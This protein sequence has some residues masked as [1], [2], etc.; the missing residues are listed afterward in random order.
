METFL[1]EV[2]RRLRADH[3]ADLDKVTVV[4]NNRRS[5]LFLRRQ[6]AQLSLDGQQAFFLPRIM[7]IDE[8]VAQLGGC[9]I[10]PNEFLL[11]ELF[12]IHRTIGGEGR[13]FATFEEFISFGDMMLA[14]FA[15]IDLYCVDVRQLFANL[16]D[17][18]AIGEWDIET[19]RLTDFQRRY[20]SFYRS[21]YDYYQQLHERLR[22]RGLAYS[23]M[24][25]RQVAEDIDRLAAEHPMA[26]VYFVGFNALSAAEKRIVQHYVRAGQGCLLTDGDDYYYSNPTQ[27]AGLFLRRQQSDFPTIGGYADHFAASPKEITIVSCPEDVA[28]CK[29]AGELLDGLMR[30]H[31]GESLEQVALVLADESLLVPAL[32]ALPGSVPT[33]NV[34]M[35]YPFTGTAVHSLM[36]K[37]FSLQLRRRG[38]GFNHQDLRDLLT[39]KCLAPMLRSENSYQHLAQLFAR[40]NILY[41][42]PALVRQ[43][44][45]EMHYNITP[46]EAILCAEPPTPDAFLAVVSDLAQR[47]FGSGALASNPREEEALGCLMEIVRHF[48]QL[49][50]QYHYVTKLTELQ[51]IYLR[52]AQRRTVA[53]YGEPLA[54][55]QV[56]GVLETRNLDFRRVILL[57]ANEGTLPS[58]RSHNSL[59]PFNLKNAFGIPTYREKEAVYAYNFY[60]LLQRA[61][62]VHILYNTET[63]GSM[64]K[65]EPSRFVLQVRDELAKCYP[66]TIAVREQVLNV[67][68]KLSTEVAETTTVA[69]DEATM[70]WLRQKAQN[71]FSPTSLNTYRQC[72]LKFYYEYV[73]GARKQDELDDEIG[74]DQLGTIIHKVLEQGYAAAPDG[75]VSEAVLQ[76]ALDRLD[77]LLDEACA[78]LFLHG[79]Q[80]EGKN[81]LMRAVAR[82]QL[83]AFLQAELQRLGQGQHELCVLGLEKPLEAELDIAEGGTPQT[84]H[85]TG[86][87]DRIDSL[88]GIVRIV[89][90]KTGTV[91]DS[92]L[93]AK[94]PNGAD[95][96]DMYKTGPKWF[97]VMLYAW[98]WRRMNPHDPRPL[99][100]GIFALKHLRSDLKVASWDGQEIITAEH[101]DQFGQYLTDLLAEILNPDLPL[102]ATPS[103]SSGYCS[104]CPFQDTCGH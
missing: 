23:G 43:L 65:G 37:L 26:P 92:E 72:P 42:D 2:A 48:Q 68:L 1:A 44:C 36:L 83:T 69:K 56:L 39:D 99:T 32:N 90:Y 16:H 50:E 49:Q 54:G 81:Y 41:A 19:G 7:G 27:E 47:L 52:L 94:T 57:S 71:G 45:Q 14:D 28:Q 60:R 29:Y 87:A 40:Q 100:S 103:S 104:Y 34:T 89:D 96:I 97:Q 91:K 67:P 66:D 9:E 17:L 86:M 64:G 6:F 4:F 63:D 74:S 62:S 101:L 78:S 95:T 53:F 82:K 21:L 13:K 22:Q 35:G 77:T 73:L 11:F 30:D 58:A 38:T 15:E 3:P 76:S 84:V 46:I 70:A 33:A 20:L 88:D 12:D 59:I 18:K 55:L 80:R 51:K 25:Y 85:F 98:M 75:R 61:D 102:T 24:A 79:R 31:A 5:G 8:F 10:V 93:A